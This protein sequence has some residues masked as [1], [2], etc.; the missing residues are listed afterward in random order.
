MRKQIEA[1]FLKVAAVILIILPFVP[2][3]D[4]VDKQPDLA[5]QF[6]SMDWVLGSA[7]A[8][9]LAWLLSYLPEKL[10]S[11]LSLSTQRLR[12]LSKVCLFCFPALVLLSLWRVFN[13]RPHLID[14]IV[15][16]FQAKIFASGLVYAPAPPLPGFFATQHMLF[17]EGRWYSQYAPLH[18]IFLAVGETLHATWLPC[19]VLS[20]S[21][22]FLMRAFCVQVYGQ[23]QAAISAILFC[24]SPFVIFMSASYMNHITSLFLAALFLFAWGRWERDRAPGYAALLGLALG[25]GFSTRSLDFIALALVFALFEAKS[26]LSPAHLRSSICMSLAGFLGALPYFL[27]NRL[28]TGDYLLPGFVKLWGKSHELGF[29]QDP[30]GEMH[31]PL[32]GL[33]N[34]LISINQ[35]N[36]FLFETPFPIL[37]I[38]GVA[39]FFGLGHEK[40]EKR[41][42]ACFFSV[43]VLYV[44]YWHRDSF[45]GPR[46]LYVTL[47]FLIP[48]LALAWQRLYDL[49]DSKT[50]GLAGVLKPVGV[51]SFLVMLLTV[52]A[53]Y[54]VLIGIPIRARIYATSLESMKVDIVK[55]A[56]AAGIQTGIIFVATSLGGRL[57]SNLRELGV[58]AS[59][60][61]TA[62][63]AV[64]HCELLGMATEAFIS[65]SKKQT[66]TEDILAR[67]EAH[68]PVQKVKLN[69]DPTLRIDLSRAPT[70]QCKEEIL[71]DRENYT[72]LEPH[73]LADSPKLDSAI[74]V[75]RDLRGRNRELMKYYPE[76]PAYLYRPGSFERLEN[77]T[78]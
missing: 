59:I 70:A 44:F 56:K 73:L 57:I 36:E 23:R 50:F 16:L 18:S 6:S 47:P 37:V 20:I 42:V 63:R 8:A 32:R 60:I 61:E 28:T 15:Q 71:Y 34:Q 35:I 17:D 54:S 3:K 31:T 72:S 39:I 9:S 11:T 68:E 14:T 13:F 53:I 21:S 26:L 64:D 7:I 40:W 41:L 55:E 30:W 29:H 67:I 78:H 46:Y 12:D 75:A 58:P 10:I 4:L 69:N 77:L 48:L 27:Y 1:T 22:A 52:C 65:E 49:C 51:R 43:P 76:L 33:L 74:V 62:Y 24:L 25:L 2:F 66:L 38:V 5:V 19:L 45:L